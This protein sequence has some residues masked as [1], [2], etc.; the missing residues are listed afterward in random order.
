L[1]TGRALLA[2]KW[3]AHSGPFPRSAPLPLIL[4][5]DVQ[6]VDD[7]GQVA[8]DGE[9][10]VDQQVGAA[11]ALEEDT[12]RRQDDGKDDLADVAVFVRTP[13]TTM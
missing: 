1:R 10:D 3:I 5:N 8:Q 12:E 4:Q 13:M 2:A 11:A 9:Q 7:T 6:G